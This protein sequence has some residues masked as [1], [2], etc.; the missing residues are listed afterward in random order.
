MYNAGRLCTHRNYS[1]FFFFQA[2]LFSIT[3]CHLS[4]S[5]QDGGSRLHLFSIVSIKEECAR[6]I[7]ERK[8]HSPRT[9]PS[10]VKKEQQKRH[11]HKEPVPC[12]WCG[13]TVL[14]V[15]A[16]QHKPA[17]MIALH[18]SYCKVF[19]SRWCR[20]RFFLLKHWF[21]KK[22]KQD[23]NFFQVL[24]QTQWPRKFSACNISKLNFLNLW[25][26]II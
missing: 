23:C 13:Q 20:S 1:T 5:R 3:N 9:H 16:L 22:R 19:C 24:D 14:T 17:Q 12:E 18:C 7:N 26:P 25:C 2:R 21:M 8:K 15:A 4:S 10:L 6:K 11:T